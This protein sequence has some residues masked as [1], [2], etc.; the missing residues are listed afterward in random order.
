[1]LSSKLVSKPPERNCQTFSLCSVL[2]RPR[3]PRPPVLF[4]RKEDAFICST[5]GLSSRRGQPPRRRCQG[6]ALQAWL[7][8]WPPLRCQRLLTLLQR[9]HLDTQWADHH[10]RFWPWRYQVCRHKYSW[11]CGFSFAVGKLHWN[12]RSTRHRSR[13][14]FGENSISNQQKAAP[15]DAP[16]DMIAVAVAEEKKEDNVKHVFVQLHFGA[17]A[18]IGEEAVGKNW[19]FPTHIPCS[20]W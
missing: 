13:C 15:S 6:E 11:I 3:P 1:M 20:P 10:P 8:Y 2:L 4:L 9:R 16:L 17:D 14:I 19:R 12:T 5:T 18:I 7:H